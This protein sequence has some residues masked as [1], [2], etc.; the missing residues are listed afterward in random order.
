MKQNLTPWFPGHI[1]PVR[2]G[3]YQQLS[4]A[5]QTIGYQ[6]W[7]GEQWGS[8]CYS[9]ELAYEHRFYKVHKEYQNDDWRGI[10]K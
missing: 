8:W 10:A 9:P 7:D 2:V 1:K 6:Y 5:N 3:L 4:K